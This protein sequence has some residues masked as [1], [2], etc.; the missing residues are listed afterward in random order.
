MDRKALD[1][2]AKKIQA[3][4]EK[5]I[6]EYRRMAENRRREILAEA[7]AELEKDLRALRTRK[8]REIKNHVNF[9]ISQAKI[10]GKRMIL[11]EREKGIESVFSEVLS[12]APEKEP[13]GYRDYLQRSIRHIKAV[14]G[15][16]S[17][18]CRKEDESEISGMLPPGWGL[19]PS[20]DSNKPGIIGRSSDGSMEV[21]FT[22]S[23]RL[24]DMKEALRKEVSETLYGG[25]V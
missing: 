20:L 17:I 21:D 23:R 24:E 18:I 12:S 16:G 14:L 4:A 6:A 22:L 19:E 13:A 2:I 15:E 10:G 8:E 9:T 5:K 1:N 7:E 3:D 25:E 11:N